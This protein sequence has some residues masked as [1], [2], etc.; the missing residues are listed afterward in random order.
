[1][2]GKKVDPQLDVEQGR[3]GNPPKTSTT[4]ITDASVGE[5]ELGKYDTNGNLNV[6]QGDLSLPHINTV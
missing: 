6:S 2:R 3:Q 4:L 5:I 1:M